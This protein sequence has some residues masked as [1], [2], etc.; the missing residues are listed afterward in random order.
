MGMLSSFLHPERA[1]KRAQRD[2]DKYYQQGQEAISP[3]MQHGQEAYGQLSGATQSLMNPTKLYDQ[4]MGD[5]QQSDASRFAQ[6]RAQNQ[7]LEA[8]S[9]MGMSGSTPGA[10]AIQAG[11]ER[12][13]AEDQQRYIDRM[14]QQYLSGAGLAQGIYGTGANAASQYGQN[15]M[16]MGQ[17]T[18]QMTYGQNAAPGQMLQNMINTGLSAAVPMYGYA[19]MGQSA[20]SGGGGGQ[21]GGLWNT[22][23]GAYNPMGGGNMIG[24]Y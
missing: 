24:G 18:A 1:Y 20:L 19:K 14:I 10:R 5:Y 7:G 22:R 23:G 9:A 21:S 13:G 6:E 2:L 15:A 8:L 3:Y 12:I 11:T 16:N 4:F 17:N